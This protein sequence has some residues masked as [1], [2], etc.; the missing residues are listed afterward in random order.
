MSTISSLMEAI[1]IV[2]SFPELLWVVIGIALGI[3][4][5]AIPGIGAAIG[6]AILLPLSL[7]MDGGLAIIFFVSMYLGGMYGG[8]IAAILINTPGT[9]AA[10]ATTL[11]GYPLSKQGLAINALSISAI[12]SAIGGLIAI[13]ILIAISPFLT[14]ILLSFGSPEYFMV[15]VLGLAMITIIAR[16]SMIKGLTMGAFGLLVSSV[17]ISEV[18]GAIRYDMGILLLFDGI[19]FVAVLIGLFAITEMLKLAGREGQISEEDSEVSGSRRE[20]VTGVLRRPV[21]VFKSSLIGLGIGAIPGAGSS[22][23]NFVAYGEAMRNDT[24]PDSFGNGNERGV[25]SA[26]SSNSATVAG[27]LIPTLSF[28]IP[29]SGTTAVL[30]GAL[31]MHGFQPGPNLFA[32]EA[33]TTYS[34]FVALLIGNFIIA[35]IGLAVIAYAGYVTQIDTDYI[36]PI[37]IPLAIFG[38]FAMRDN[39]IDIVTVVLFGI[40][41]YYMVKY[42]YS[43]I[44]LVLGVVLG[45]IAE[46]N[47]HRSL[48]ISDGSYL[49]FVQRPISLLMVIVTIAILFGPFVKA[50]Y[51]QYKGAEP[52]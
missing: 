32:Q 21:T 16:G 1:V 31:L 25:I 35:L 5:G 28:G 22:V 6:M 20:G 17:G 10:A 43:I 9:A 48:Q 24:N 4:L 18:G 33:V 2:F 11:D 52:A 26:E 46:T 44:A 8:S 27:S 42:D 30:L 34:F 36:I 41:G 15:A 14:S 39:P 23:S 12:S 19:D 38:S 51:Q 49:I 45:P 37:I 40:L 13:I 29:G 50:Q 3:L 47:L 7:Q